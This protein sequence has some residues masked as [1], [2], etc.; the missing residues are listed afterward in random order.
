MI[1]VLMAHP[2]SNHNLR[3]VNRSYLDGDRLAQVS[4]RP[5]GVQVEALRGIVR[6]YEGEDWI[7]H[8]VVEG[9]S[10]QFVE[11]HEVVEIGDGAILPQPENLLGTGKPEKGKETLGLVNPTTFYAQIVIMI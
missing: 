5:L 4:E 10:S 11:L 9:P 8:E 7:L 6:K 3:T 2:N 1:V